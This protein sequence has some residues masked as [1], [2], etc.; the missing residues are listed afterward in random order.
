[1]PVDT[2]PGSAT[3]VDIR[4][5]YERDGFVFPLPLL[6]PGESRNLLAAYFEFRGAHGAELTDDRRSAQTLV[7]NQTHLVLDWVAR[8]ATRPS[9]LD[10]VELLIGPDLALWHSQ[11]MVKMPHAGGLANAPLPWH[12][13]EVNFAFEPPVAVT[14]WIALSP[15][16]R[17]NGA[18]QFVPGSHTGA[19]LSFESNARDE[20]SPVTRGP[21]VG[22]DTT[23]AVDVCLQPGEVSFHHPRLVH[24]SGTNGGDAPRVAILLR[25]VPTYVRSKGPHPVEGMMVRG[26]AP[27]SFR[28]LEP[29]AGGDPA[30]L[31][32]DNL[33]RLQENAAVVGY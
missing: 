2:A 23:S 32:R 5:R 22:I 10:L 9:I 7:H 18:M 8:L 13:D 27:R 29:G 24:A 4:A 16:T 17:E 26:D 6:S 1:M 30:V 31:Q 3:A 11:W 33:R 19:V 21:V 14:A 20:R 28:V 15:A 12:Q 25:Y